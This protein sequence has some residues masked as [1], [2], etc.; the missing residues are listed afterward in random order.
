MEYEMIAEVLEIPVGT[1]KSR[2]HRGR[3]KLREKL[4]DFV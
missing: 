1:M 4:K 3:M 2:L